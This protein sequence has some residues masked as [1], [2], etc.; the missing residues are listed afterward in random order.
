MLRVTF[1]GVR[2]SIAAPGPETV[3]Y[4]GN[5][6]CVAVQT[7][8]DKLFILDAGTGIIRLGGSL[9]ADAFGRGEGEVTILL[10]HGHWDHIQGFPFFPPV[11]VPKNRVTIYGPAHSN[12]IVEGILEGQMNPHFSPV[13]S[14]GNLGAEITC[15]AVA[16]GGGGEVTLGA[17]RVRSA[18]V[19]HGS[20]TSLAYRLDNGG[21]SLVYCPDAGY[22]DGDPSDEVLSLFD[23]ADCLIHD[24]TYTPE[25]G[26]ARRARGYSSIDVTAKVAA[27]AGVKQLVMF[28][29]DQDYSDGDVDALAARCRT[30]LDAEAGGDKV[31]LLAAREGLTITV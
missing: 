17:L 7:E 21:S 18:S 10:T 15:K 14:L 28:H 25:D 24:C 29:Y 13:Q 6:S 16:E 11:Y 9:M 12:S 19:P 3:R 8:D 23:G 1:W 20:I 30:L 26:E 31:E 2:G 27:R 22:I 4:G 5:T